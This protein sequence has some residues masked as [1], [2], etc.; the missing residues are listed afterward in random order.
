MTQTNN[1]EL[2]ELKNTFKYPDDYTVH[3]ISAMLDKAF[4]LGEK[5]GI[6]KAEKCVPEEYDMRTAIAAGSD[7][8]A[9]HVIGHNSLRKE[10]LDN[11]AKIKNL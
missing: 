9:G 3:R 1:I 11:L 7:A 4:A 10:I 2:A 8:G 5:S 6:A